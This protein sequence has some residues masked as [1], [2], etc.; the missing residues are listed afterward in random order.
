[1]TPEQLELLVKDQE[2]RI[3]DLEEEIFKIMHVVE[4]PAGNKQ[5][6]TLRGM[7]QKI[8][9]QVFSKKE[10]PNDNAGNDNKVN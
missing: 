10:F 4:T 7:V 8:Y 6:L 5:F 9:N 3:K 2:Q 1:M